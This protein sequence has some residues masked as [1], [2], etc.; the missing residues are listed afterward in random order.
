LQ[1]VD[2]RFETSGGIKENRRPTLQLK[3][4][5]LAEKAPGLAAISNRQW[6]IGNRFSPSTVRR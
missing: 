1:I 3:C 6:A 4:P 2:C 5:H